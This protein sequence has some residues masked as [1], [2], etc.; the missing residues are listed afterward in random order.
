MDTTTSPEF[1]AL[2]P[3]LLHRRAVRTPIYPGTVSVGV[4]D[5][6]PIVRAGLVDF[7]SGESGIHVAGQASDAAG[8]LELVRTTPLDVLMLD[9]DLPG[10]SG[11]DILAMLRSKVPDLA[12]L[13]FT[14][15]PADRYAVKLLQQGAKAYLQKTCE[16]GELIT[17]LRTLAAGRRY[18]T[19]AVSDLIAGQFEKH[20]RPAHADLTD[21]EL[22]VLLKL[23]RG[24]RT[25]KIADH[26]ALSVKT[27]SAYRARL[28][29]KLELG[30]NNDLTYY[31]LKHQL[32]E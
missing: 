17:A 21:R 24:V 27:I 13:V 29:S 20:S 3:A 18:L 22:Q 15:Y 31:A 6:H 11:L 2:T 26:L 19:P 8:A 10:R 14:G 28:L 5:D 12:V 32:L 16:L 1:K 9:L 23:A 7:L 4:V 30:S 25:E